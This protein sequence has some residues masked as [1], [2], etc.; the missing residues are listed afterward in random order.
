MAKVPVVL[1]SE[2]GTGIAEPAG[3]FLYLS[4]FRVD[5]YGNITSE[6]VIRLLSDFVSEAGRELPTDQ[7]KCCRAA[8]QLVRDRTLYGMRKIRMK[9]YKC[10]TFYSEHVCHMTPHIIA[11]HASCL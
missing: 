9:G 8:N 6:A 3:E 5:T 11:L 2:H 1:V 4:V 7:G 10:E